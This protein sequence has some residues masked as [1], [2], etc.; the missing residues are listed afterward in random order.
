[1]TSTHHYPCIVIVKSIMNTALVLLIVISEISFTPRIDA[2]GDAHLQFYPNVFS[3]RSIRTLTIYTHTQVVPIIASINSSETILHVY[4]ILYPLDRINPF[5][6][7]CF[8]TI[9][10]FFFNVI[11]FLRSASCSYVDVVLPWSMLNILCKL[12]LRLSVVS[13]HLASKCVRANLVLSFYY[14]F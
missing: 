3:V 1:M 8:V 4:V 5:F 7:L 14:A 10:S 2:R 6:L 9:V 11:R 13:N 12:S